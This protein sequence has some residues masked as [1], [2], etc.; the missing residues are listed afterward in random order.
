M[1]PKNTDIVGVPMA[2][3]GYAVPTEEARTATRTFPA[4]A[5][6]PGLNTLT[7]LS[8]GGTYWVAASEALSWVAPAP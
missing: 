8:A 6:V 1:T 3:I 2:R 4:V 5:D 7:T